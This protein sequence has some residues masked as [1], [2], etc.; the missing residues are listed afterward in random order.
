[1]PELMKLDNLEFHKFF[2]IDAVV[3]ENSYL[4][5][6][7]INGLTKMSGEAE[8]CEEMYLSPNVTN[9]HVHSTVMI[10]REYAERLPNMSENTFKATDY[11]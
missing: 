8:Q 6:N 2:D 9:R 1:M 3:L 7:D 10:L 11:Y 5:D 4:N